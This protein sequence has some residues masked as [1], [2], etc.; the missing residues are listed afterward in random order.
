MAIC[1]ALTNSDIL[2]LIFKHFD[3]NDPRQDQ[4]AW[5][6]AARVRVVFYEPVIRLIWRRL[7][8]VIPLFSLLPSSFRRVKEADETER[9]LVEYDAYVGISIPWSLDEQRRMK[10][11]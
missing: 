1:A 9:K 4:P 5:A 6:R 11:I 3:S 2:S 10:F 7:D 8:S